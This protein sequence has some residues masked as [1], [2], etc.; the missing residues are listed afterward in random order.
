MN[1]KT[2]K[3]LLLLEF[4]LGIQ[5][6]LLGQTDSGPSR[7]D[8]LIS[9]IMAKPAPQTG[10]PAVEYIELHNR[11][12][13]PVNLQNWQLKLGNTVKKLPDIALPLTEASE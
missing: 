6:G 7:Y 13:H 5:N 8:I 11:L 4:F 9:E 1:V 2:L 12:P 10:L 3:A